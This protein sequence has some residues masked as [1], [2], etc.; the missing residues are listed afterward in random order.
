M[1]FMFFIWKLMF[2]TSTV[3]ATVF[4]RRL[5]ATGGKNIPQAYLEF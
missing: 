5:P 1:F 3:P 2:L 4:L